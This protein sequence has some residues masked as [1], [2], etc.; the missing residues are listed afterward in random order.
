MSS[1]VTVNLFS[2]RLVINPKPIDSTSGVNYLYAFT[3]FF[4]EIRKSTDN[5]VTFQ[6]GWKENGLVLKCVIL[7]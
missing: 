5:S 3:T 4:P 6:V 2:L 7:Y 1:I